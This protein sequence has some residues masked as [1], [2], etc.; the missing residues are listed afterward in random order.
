MRRDELRFLEWK[1]IDFKRSKIKIR[2]KEGFQ[3][4]TTEREIPISKKLYA[5]LGRLAHNGSYIISNSDGQ[6]WHRN[7]F[8]NEFMRIAKG[9][10]LQGVTK[11][12]SL[13]HTFASH[14][15]MAGV[16]LA[17]VQKLMG[18]RNIQTTMI[19]AHLSPG[20]LAQAVDK[21]NY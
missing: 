9:A 16:D 10:G 19:Y 15:V 6:P 8:R 12:H 21:L 20:H 5:V 17:S 3:P 1:D 2:A 13:R 18:H 14:L 11:L 4:K 7:K